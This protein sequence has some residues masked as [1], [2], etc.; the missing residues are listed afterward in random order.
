MMRRLIAAAIASPGTGRRAMLAAGIRWAAAIVFLIF[1]A[2]KF[3]DHAAELA[4]FRHYPL[5]V[6]DVAVYAVAAL[7]ITG[8]LLLAIGLLTTLAALALAAD[9][10]GAI[11][12]SGL[13]R[14]EI[15][16]LT[17]APALLAAMISLIRS[18]AGDYSLDRHLAAGMSR[19]RAAQP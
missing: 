2:A 19:P 5:P 11:I 3:T 14:R 18:G 16:S 6:P 8:G 13:A 9:M 15:I 1:G 7:E 10:V 4:S 12:V 17:L